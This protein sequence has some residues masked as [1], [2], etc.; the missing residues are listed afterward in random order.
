M[1]FCP[2]YHYFNEFGNYVCTG[3]NKCSEKYNKLILFKNQCIDEC[4]NDTIYK[5]EYKNNCYI[6]CPLKTIYN[7]SLDKCVK[8]NEPLNPIEEEKRISNYKELI[9]KG[10]FNN[11]LDNIIYNNEEYNETSGEIMYH[12]TSTEIQK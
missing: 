4:K 6:Q 2:F 12:I 3:E 8:A 7:K 11:I 1:K 5:Y 10:S 9:T